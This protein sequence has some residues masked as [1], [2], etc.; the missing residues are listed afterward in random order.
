MPRQEFIDLVN[1]VKKEG[2]PAVLTIRNLLWT[3]GYYESATQMSMTFTN[4]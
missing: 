3:F 1:K 4:L 2:K